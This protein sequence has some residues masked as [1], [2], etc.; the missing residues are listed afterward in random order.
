MFTVFFSAHFP[1]DLVLPDF[2]NGPYTLD[3][4]MHLPHDS[5]EG[6]IFEFHMNL[7]MLYF[8]RETNALSSSHEKSVIEYLN[9]SMCSLSYIELRLMADLVKSV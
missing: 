2:S 3:N 1:G 8:L 9:N 4:M 6:Y 5:S 7:Q